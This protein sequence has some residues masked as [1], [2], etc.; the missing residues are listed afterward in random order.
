MQFHLLILYSG[1]IAQKLWIVQNK[2]KNS[3]KRKKIWMLLVRHNFSTK[4]ID[5]CRNHHHHHSDDNFFIFAT[6]ILICKLKD[7]SYMRSRIDKKNSDFFR[8][9]LKKTMGLSEKHDINLK[10]TKI[11]PCDN[12]CQSELAL[13]SVRRVYNTHE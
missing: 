8:R 3:I 5:H 11:P 10:I 7:F 2:N 13:A 12:G 9:R 4:I 1:T 6:T